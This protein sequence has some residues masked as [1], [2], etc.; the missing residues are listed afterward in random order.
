MSIGLTGASGTGAVGT[1]TPATTVALTGVAGTG[2][3]GL[4][5][6]S[7]NTYLTITGV[8]WT[9]H[10]GTIVIQETA[11]G[12]NTFSGDIDSLTGSRPAIGAE[13][14]M[15]EAGTRI[16]GGHVTELAEEGQIGRAHV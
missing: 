4:V 5:S 12:P 10:T 9:M 6:S 13:L 14:L 7:G 3:V 11:N 15:V 16:F 8:T 2:G 1:E